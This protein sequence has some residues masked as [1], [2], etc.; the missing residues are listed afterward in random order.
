MERPFV[1]IMDVGASSV[2]LKLKY[3]NLQGGPVTIN[4]DLKGEKRI[5]QALQQYQGE[6]VAM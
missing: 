3:H 6:G 1:A 2:Y 5:Y 4:V